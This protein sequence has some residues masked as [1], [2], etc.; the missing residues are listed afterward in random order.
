MADS[1]RIE[2]LK[3]RV[4]LD[5]ASI[6]FAALAEEYRRAGQFEDAIATCR[7]GCSG[8]PPTCPPASRWAGR[9]SRL[10]RYD[11]AR[12]NSNR[13]CASAPENLA[14]IRGLAEIHHRAGATCPRAPRSSNRR[15][16]PDA[17]TA[18][19]REPI[20]TAGERASVHRD[21]RA[22]CPQR[23]YRSAHPHCTYAADRRPQPVA[24]RHR[25][26]P[27][28]LRRHR[29]P[30]A[31]GRAQPRPVVKR[32]IRT[33][34]RSR[35]SRR[36]WRR[37]SPRQSVGAASTTVD[38][39][40]PQSE[41]SLFARAA[42]RPA[43]PR[44]DGPRRAPRHASAQS[45]LS[46]RL[47]RQHGR[48]AAVGVRD[49][50][51]IVD[52]R[53]ITGRAIGWPR[54]TV[55]ATARRAG[56]RAA[57]RRPM[58]SAVI[59]DCGSGTVG[60]EAAVND[61]EPLRSAARAARSGDE[62]PRRA[63]GASVPT[64]RVVE[65]AR[66]IKDAARRSRRCVRPAAMLSTVAARAARRWSSPAGRSATSPADIDALLRRRD[67]SRPAFDTIVA[68]GPNSALPHARPGRRRLAPGDSVVLDFGGV[69]DGYCV[70]LT[71]TVQLAPGER[72]FRRLFEAVRAAH[73]AAI[74]AVGP[75]CRPARS[76]R[77]PARC[78]RARAGRGVRPRHRARLG[79]EVHEEPRISPAG[80]RRRTR[81]GAAAGWSSR[82]SRAPTC[83]ASAASGS[84][85]TCW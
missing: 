81:R 7:P 82:S 39:P 19:E 43:H 4:Q 46:H 29:H 42:C 64:E 35:R 69:Y 75:G 79:L 12:T 14:A 20:P 23:E 49:A 5:P 1:A 28:R 13:S 68:S 53:Y 57:S 11:E 73:A 50:V 65:R 8:I 85:T 83:R 58:A 47:R 25:F 24:G 59:R 84:K 34:R 52:G 44:R 26:A 61:A 9:C 33:T 17:S 22:D 3:R 2:E 56:A 48:A 41:P 10:G 55:C 51:L 37:S 74:A 63:G 77:R 54:P 40:A 76:T 67:S 15:R 62:L 80:I 60:V 36:F 38:S 78:W 66:M 21:R 16:P 71:R 32:R 72:R 70:D 31:A 6:A 18:P 27:L 30:A 45:A